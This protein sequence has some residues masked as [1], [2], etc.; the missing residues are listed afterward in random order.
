VP[1]HLSGEPAEVAAIRDRLPSAVGRAFVEVTDEAQAQ[2]LVAAEAGSV[3]VVR[4]AAT[5]QLPVVVRTD[6]GV[7]A[8]VAVLSQVARWITLALLRNPTT[9]LAPDA[10]QV[11]LLGPDDARP[12]AG[13]LTVGY[14]GEVA[15]QVLLRLTNTAERPLW[16][17]VLDLTET[18]GVYADAFPAGAVRLA[19]GQQASVSLT[20]QIPDGIWAKG[21]DESSD[22]LKVVVSTEQLDARLLGQPDL[23]VG[24]ARPADV[25]R[26]DVVPQT[27]LD[28]LM[29]RVVTRAAPSA[30]AHGQ[31]LADW[32]ASELTVTVSRPRT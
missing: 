13:L 27:T 20:A 3:N 7:D 21:A 1:V 17:A 32:S 22:V 30:P 8:A 2:L 28:A 9:A 10:V 11:E 29:Q 16:C 31:R 15:P 12:D 14:A 18:Y 5:T 4:P 6:D 24:D 23:E 25:V 19:P 26:A